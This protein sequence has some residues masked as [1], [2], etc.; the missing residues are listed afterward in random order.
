MYNLSI[1]KIE[2]KEKYINIKKLSH[3]ESQISKE[4]SKYNEEKNIKN[5]NKNNI[6]SI[7]NRILF[8]KNLNLNKS[9]IFHSMSN[10]FNQCLDN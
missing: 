6:K 9:A 4:S 10:D 7:K 1:N 3:F 8:L 2:K 5:I